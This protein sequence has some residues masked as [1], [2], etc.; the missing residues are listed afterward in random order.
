MMF[1]R[2]FGLTSIIHSGSLF[3]PA[4]SVLDFVEVVT[5]LIKLGEVKAWLR[6]SA[7]WGIVGA[8]QGLLDSGVAW[9]DD[10]VQE[11]VDLVFD[12]DQSWSQ[13]KIAVALL[14][15]DRKPVCLPYHTL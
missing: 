13:E 8:I 15:Q 1:A 12:Q 11:I 3:G 9:E 10:A 14:L 5:Q 7:W 4:S 6:E 2:L